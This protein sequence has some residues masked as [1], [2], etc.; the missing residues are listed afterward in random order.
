MFPERRLIQDHLREWLDQ[1][2]LQRIRIRSHSCLTNTTPCLLV[3]PDPA[4]GPAKRGQRLR[5][6]LTKK[7]HTLLQYGEIKGTIV[8]LHGRN[9]RKED[10]LAVAE[11]F[12]A[13][14]FRCLLPDLPAHGESARATAS[15]V[16]SAFDQSFASS[17]LQ[18]MEHAYHFKK[19]PS[20]LWGMSM[21]GAFT[22]A[23]PKHSSD[24]WS[25][26]VIVCSF[27]SLPT[28]I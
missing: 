18:E 5:D 17:V 20:Y 4:S 15:F 16:L 1:P 14:G 23:A 28:I 8:L 21:G 22:S 10:L 25:T 6:R 11:R 3:T 2:N 27:D 7:N 26:A 9:G 24:R 19:D 12:C 13:V